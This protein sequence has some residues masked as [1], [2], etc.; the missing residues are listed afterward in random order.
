MYQNSKNIENKLCFEGKKTVA[1]Y[2]VIYSPK[3]YRTRQIFTGHLHLSIRGKRWGGR[4]EWVKQIEDFFHWR[5]NL[6]SVIGY[7]ITNFKDMNL[8]GFW[9]LHEVDTYIYVILMDLSL[10]IFTFWHKNQSWFLIFWDYLVL[11]WLVTP[12]PW[13]ALGKPRAA[14]GS[15]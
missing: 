4:E 1:K 7:T 9:V 8:T 11:L 3:I 13:R 5:Y 6:K 14:V 2:C 10:T 12:P 15:S